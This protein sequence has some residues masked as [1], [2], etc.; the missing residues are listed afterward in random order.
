MVDIVV[1]NSPPVASRMQVQT[2]V[3]L[4]F[5]DGMVVPPTTF[6]PYI[7]I[8]EDQARGESLT[9]RYWREGVDDQNS[10]G[11]ADESEYQSQNRELSV[12]LT[13]EQQVQFMG[14]DVSSMDNELIH[15]YVEGTDWVGL[16]YQDGSTGGGPGATNSWASVVVAEDVMVEFAG[17]GLGTGSGGGSTFSLDRLTQ[18]SI[19][20]F[21]V[22]GIEHTFKVRLDE[23]NG[24]RTI[25]NISVF[26][27]GYGSE[28]GVFSYE[29]FTSTLMSPSSSMLDVIGASTEAITSTVT[30]L[31]GR[32]KIS[33]DMPF[34][35]QDFD[36]KPRVLVED[37]LDQIESEVLSSLS[38]RLDN[39]ISAIPNAA[40]DLS[41]PIIPAL[42]TSLYLGQGD[43]FSV[44]GSVHHEGSG[45]RIS[46]VNQDLT[47]VLS[48]TYGSG[49]YESLGAV[50][51]NGN[52]TVEMTLPNFQ[53]IEPTTVLTTSLIGVPGNAHSVEDSQ[54]SVTVDTKPPTALF[55]VEAYPDSSLTVIETNNMD[56]VTVTI[57]IIEELS[58]IHI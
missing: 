37:G 40:E 11:I 53:P 52:F 10:D 33:W 16:S 14:I 22:P 44:S 3:G 13:G 32:F 15:L 19:D 49:N 6:S 41:E 39:R 20:Y 34:T 38:W 8:S 54:A 55:N 7:T 27:C 5:V 35:E 9:L 4:Q 18:D 42:G 23:P 2:P 51:A 57:T 29:P 26:L 28:Y 45:I 58:L 1:D 36:C 43:T 48:M 46:E 21:L 47:A 31:S 25:D 24:F 17:A 30:E 56:S 50:D 12:G